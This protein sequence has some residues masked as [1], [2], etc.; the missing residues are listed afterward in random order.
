MLPYS[1]L[2]RPGFTRPEGYP[3][4]GEL[5]PHRFTLTFFKAVFF[6]VALSFDHSKLPLTADLSCEAPTFLPYHWV[7]AIT[8]LAP[9]L[10][11]NY[12]ALG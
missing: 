3:P 2:L 8:H 6:S 12:G 5:L 1:V 7:P 10:Y 4:A 11:N 9:H